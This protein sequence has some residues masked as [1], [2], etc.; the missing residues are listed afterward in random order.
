[1]YLGGFDN[2]MAAA[3]A[4]DVMAIKTRGPRTLINFKIEVYQAVLPFL[5]AEELTRVSA[6]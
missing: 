5:E 1:M 4:H 2:E 3:K 6:G